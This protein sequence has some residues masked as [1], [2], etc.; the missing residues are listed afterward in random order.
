M[1][2]K[3][4]TELGLQ[5]GKW[6]IDPTHS[7]IG[8]SARHMMVS[9]VRGFFTEFSGDV[10]VAEDLTQSTVSVTIQSASITTR[11]TDRDN[12]V[13]S[14]DFLDVENHPTLTFVSQSISP[15]GSDYELTGALT[16]R[17]ITN[18]ITFDLEFDSTGPD[19]YGGVRA[20]LNASTKISR[21][22]FGLEWNPAL[23][24]GGFVVADEVKLEI[25]VE[26]VK[27]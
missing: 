18:P 15:K 12:H 14:A 20:G 22:A 5:T 9:K 7:Q 27:A 11:Q 26:L 13:R 25:E 23:E 10:E 16:I 21:K 17:G 1:S 6:T 4:A 2:A 8:F 24:T 3:T 19:A